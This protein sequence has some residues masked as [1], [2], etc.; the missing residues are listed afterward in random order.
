MGMAVPFECLLKETPWASFPGLTPL[1]VTG[2]LWV[3]VEAGRAARAWTLA[4]EGE[5]AAQ[6][7]QG[8][9]ARGRAMGGRIPVQGGGR[10]S[11]LSGPTLFSTLS[12]GTL[13]CSLWSPGPPRCSSVTLCDLRLVSGCWGG[14]GGHQ[15]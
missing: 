13:S 2:A 8:C 1:H 7:P 15:P 9:G 14:V 10:Q 12:P 11:F 5:T 4:A 3:W 6:M